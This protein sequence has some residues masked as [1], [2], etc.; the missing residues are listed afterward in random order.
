MQPLKLKEYV[1]TLKPVVIRRLPATVPWSDCADIVDDADAFAGA[2]LARLTGGLPEEQLRS[3]V[4]L[5]V[6]G[7]KAKAEQFERWIDGIE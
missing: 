5:D 4:R 1:A 2:I 7:W 6:E 3:R